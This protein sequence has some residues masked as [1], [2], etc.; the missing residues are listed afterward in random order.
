MASAERGLSLRAIM[1][2][3]ALGVALLLP[4]GLRY[5]IDLTTCA[6]WPPLGTNIVACLV[7]WAALALLSVAWLSVPRAPAP[8]GGWTLPRV[9]ALGLPIHLLAMQTPPFLSRDPLAYA[10]IGRLIGRFHGSPYRPLTE[11]LPPGD[12]YLARLPLHWQGRG[13]A[14]FPGFNALAGLLDRLV[15]ALAGDDLARRLMAFQCVSLLALLCTAALLSWA[16]QK[17]AQLDGPADSDA[18]PRAALSFLL[19]PLVLIEGTMTAHN[20]AL[21]STSVALFVCA[22]LARRPL[23]AVLS[24]AL[25]LLVK[26]SALIPLVVYGGALV[27]GAP[28]VARHRRAALG[29]GAAGLVVGLL[30]GLPL[31]HRFTP[32]LGSPRD[33]FEYC[34]RSIECIPRSLLRY[35]LDA[36]TAAWI[37]GLCF[38][39]LGGLFLLA[40]AVRA[41]RRQQLLQTLAAAFLFYYLYLHGWYQSWYWLSLLPLLPFADPRQ[42]PAMTVLCISAVA[43]YG[44]VLIF[45][46][47]TAPV[48]VALVDLVEGLMTV[49]PP[50]LVLLRASRLSPVPGPPDAA[51]G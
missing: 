25:G 10:T 49:V 20:D 6:A 29:L 19:C 14:Y 48:T 1:A 16:V 4:I 44:L 5:R 42:R 17:K 43:F 34:T 35:I 2:L 24:L 31:L 41:A 7:Y 3:S 8:R 40:M 12:P 47:A 27:L 36:P 45:D 30:I 38:R 28:Q 11:G 15:G 33:P 26:A 37:V 18:G 39:G 21:L 13:S 23:L 46:C 50:T 51:H 9:L 32:L 22:F